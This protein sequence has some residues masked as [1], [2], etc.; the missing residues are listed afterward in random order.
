METLKISSKAFEEGGNIPPRYTCDGDD[1]S[2]LLRIQGIPEKA[3]TLVLIMDDPDIPDSVK[4]SRG[5]DVFDHW[6]KWD[7]PVTGDTMIFEEGQEPSGVSG[8]NSSGEL[9]Y[10]GP[11]PPD[12]EHRYFFKIYALDS[13]L[14]LKEGASQKEVERAM[15]GHIIASGGLMGRYN[16]QKVVK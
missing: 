7:I 6:V 11:C 10:H 3:K 5:I 1:V 13:E 8:K 15:Q 12:R 9:S 16:R 14:G 4:Q 2:P